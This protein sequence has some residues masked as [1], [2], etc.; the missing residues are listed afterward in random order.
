[1]IDSVIIEPIT[2]ND[3][4]GFFSLIEA[5]RARLSLYFPNT[6]SRSSDRPSTRRYLKELISLS[7]KREYFCFAMRDLEGGP[8]IGA[9]FLKQ[10]DWNIPK[11]ETA[12]FISS[13]Y[14]GLGL[15]TLGLIWAT[16]YAFS[17]LGGEQGV[18]SDRTGQQRRASAWPKSAAT[19]GKACCAA[20]SAPAMGGCWTFTSMGTS[21][22]RGPTARTGLQD[23]R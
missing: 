9:V 17:D 12:Y 13:I 19:S 5:E 16:D 3:D 14:E 21:V 8:P 10:F 2:K 22:D 7:Q 11:C 20:T 23:P 4:E 18:R 15:T 6:T 1:M